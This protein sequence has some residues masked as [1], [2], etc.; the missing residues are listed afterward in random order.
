MIK[1]K[2]SWLELLIAAVIG[3]IRRIQCLRA[4]SRP[5]RGGFLSGKAQD[6]WGADIE[7]VAAEHAVCKYMNWYPT[8]INKQSVDAGKN[9][10][11]R[12]TAH[13]DGH[14]IV[15]EADDD[16]LLMILV[17]GDAP[18]LYICGCI[19]AKNAKDPKYWREDKPKTEY[20]VPQSDLEEL[21]P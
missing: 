7:G 18:V 5:L 9:A 1:I 21:V 10:G 14:L 8:G 4:G 20:W 16:K 17:V 13:L 2:L 19:S 11:V 15:Y 12:R 6:P 3:V